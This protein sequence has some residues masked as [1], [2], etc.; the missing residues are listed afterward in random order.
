[1]KEEKEDKVKKIYEEDENKEDEAPLIENKKLFILVAVILGILLALFSLKFFLK[2]KLPFPYYTY[3]GFEFYQY[4][5]LWNT[6][7]Q[8]GNNLYDVHIR[9]GP[10]E[11]EDVPFYAGFDVSFNPQGMLFLTHDPKES[12]LGYVAL[13]SAEISFTLSQVFNVTPIA[14]CTQNTT[15][16]CYTR[17]IVNCEISPENAVIYLKEIEDPSQTSIS[18]NGNCMLIQGNKEELVRAVDKVIWIWYGIIK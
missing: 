2:P 16:A 7:W 6:Q 9:Y 18:V 13:A 8:R 1:M 14:A 15:E 12:G 5:G 4:G 17:P 10:R 11:S 3:N